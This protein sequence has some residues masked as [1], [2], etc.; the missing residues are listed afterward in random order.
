MDLVNKFKELYHE[1]KESRDV[2]NMRVFGRASKAMYY[3]LAEAHP[4]MAEEWLTMLAPIRC[5]NYLTDEEATQIVDGFVNQDG[6]KGAHWDKS[7]FEQAVIRL[8]GKLE[9]TPHYNHNALW[10]TANMIYSDHAQ[11]IAED[12]GFP[13]VENVPNEKMAKSCYLKAV[14]KLHDPDRP[15]FIR[16]YFGLD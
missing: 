2:A 10:V 13:M 8:G 1:M 5:H 4:E 6:Q 3:K 15:R 11:S 14:E 12:M 16:A 7:T 9:D